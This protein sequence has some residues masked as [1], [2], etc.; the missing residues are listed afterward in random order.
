MIAVSPKGAKGTETALEGN[1]EK[2]KLDIDKQTLCFYIYL[3]CNRNI[4]NIG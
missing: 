4:V 2:G 1:R 3:T